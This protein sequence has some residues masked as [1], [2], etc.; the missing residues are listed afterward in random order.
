MAD[1]EFRHPRLAAIYD[2]L[3]PDRSDLDVYVGLIEE[4]GGRQILD[5]GCGTGTLAIAL[6]ARGYGVTGVDT[7]SASLAVAR[8]KDTAHRVRWIDGDATA[9]HVTNQDVTTMTAN[10][11]QAI[12][13]PQSWDI[14][15]QAIHAAL[16]PGGYLIFE[17]R[18]PADEAWQRWTRD[19]TYATTDVAGVGTVTSW[20]DVT[21]VDGPLV[22][23]R[24]TWVFDSDGHTLTSESTLRF[25]QR[26]EIES[27]LINHGYSVVEVRDA[28]DRPGREFIFIAQRV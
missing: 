24:S 13:D 23:F 4:L 1:E 11:A 19:N 16:R 10:V 21:T 15:L 26:T 2:A 6:A 28:P 7:A 25:Q 27:D 22:T 17:S 9:A 20:T 12:T 18:D 3:D 14:T 5:V 8:T